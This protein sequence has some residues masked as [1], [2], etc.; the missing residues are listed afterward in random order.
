[1]DFLD[2]IFPYYQERLAVLE[3]LSLDKL[4][5]PQLLSYLNEASFLK[6]FIFDNL[7]EGYKDTY[8]QFIAQLNAVARLDTVLTRGLKLS[9]GQEEELFY[10]CQE[11]IGNPQFQEAPSYQVYLLEDYSAKLADLSLNQID[12]AQLAKAGEKWQKKT[13]AVL[14]E[15]VS[16]TRWVLAKT[17]QGSFICLLR[18]ALIP[19]LGLKA[20]APEREVVPMLVSRKFLAKHQGV[21]YASIT[22]PI[23][24]VL[25]ANPEGGYPDFC[26]GY[27]QEIAKDTN[28]VLAGARAN[29]LAYLNA[30]TRADGAYTVIESGVQGS[31]PL[32]LQSLTPRV[33]NFWMYT[34]APWLFTQ[35]RDIIFRQNYNY[36]RE[37]ETL[38]C[39]NNLFD[40]HAWEGGKLYI[41]ENQ[42]ELVRTLAFY[43]LVRFK[44][45][46]K[47]LV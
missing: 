37:M 6:K 36:L 28:P 34:T 1:M 16:F 5:R 22:P 33:K 47:E 20:L 35:Y 21:F 40:F 12:Q 7:E 24:S 3:G 38:V 9:G 29:V 8:T 17:P 46:L 18:D 11:R 39:Q 44:E 4:S 26:L 14:R 15:M 10:L 30:M 41:K 27:A 43:E 13:E 19:Y 42:D 23:Y 32:F 25:S 31:M 2:Y 45:L